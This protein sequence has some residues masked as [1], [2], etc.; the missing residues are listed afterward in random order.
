[1]ALLRAGILGCGA[2]AHRHAQAL[3][4]LHEEVEMVAFCN[5]TVSKAQAFSEQYTGGKAAVFSDHH[6]LLAETELDLLV[7]C[8]APHAHTDEVE[9]AAARGVHLLLEKP[10]ALSSEHAWRMVAAAEAAGIK[11]Q[12]GFQS[13]FGEAVER[14]KDMLASGAAGEPGLI[15]ARYFCNSLH[16]EW[17]RNRQTSGGQLVEQVIH[18][19]DVIRYFMGDP[20]TVYCRQA[21]L[22][23]KDIPDYTVEDVSATVF[24]FPG[25]ALGVIYATNGAIPGLWVADYRLVARRLT[26]EFSDANH[27]V[28]TYTSQP[29]NPTEVIASEKDLN[30]AQMAQ[31]IHAIRTD[32]TTRAPIREGAKTLDLALAATRSAQTGQEIRL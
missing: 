31:L 23:H 7:I 1:M 26:A 12:V 27:A 19:I 3:A 11:T 15:A 20:E 13:R 17:W 6:D 18:M 32:G 16:T 30:L 25:G 22:F 10:I 14:L 8:L 21:N 2:F 29:G 24:G 28:F 5:R 4:A 9:V